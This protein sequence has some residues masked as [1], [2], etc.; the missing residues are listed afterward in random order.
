MLRFETN[1]RCTLRVKGQSV[2]DAYEDY[3]WLNRAN[4][5]KPMAQ[6]MCALRSSIITIGPILHIELY[7][8]QFVPQGDN[9]AASMTC[10]KPIKWC[11]I[12]DIL[13]PHYNSYKQFLGNWLLPASFV[14][15]NV[16]VIDPTHTHTH[17]YTH[18][19]VVVSNCLSALHRLAERS[20]TEC[21]AN[22]INCIKWTSETL[23]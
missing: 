9:R 14:Q 23:T 13:I 8:V 2:S 12:G 3:C 21:F 7:R 16:T 17:T 15:R 22:P 10:V 4:P 1:M 5:T 11:F 19:Y 20:S 6:F 18:P